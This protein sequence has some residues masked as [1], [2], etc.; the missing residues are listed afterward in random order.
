MERYIYIK[1]PALHCLLL[2]AQ[3]FHKNWFWLK[4]ENTE[5]ARANASGLK[6]QAKP[7]EQNNKTAEHKHN[8]SSVASNIEQP[9]NISKLSL[10]TVPC[11]ST[12]VEHSYLLQT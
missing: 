1:Y 12:L 5:T 10:Q 3:R 4:T 9:T 7:I 2:S 6:I 11:T 8:P